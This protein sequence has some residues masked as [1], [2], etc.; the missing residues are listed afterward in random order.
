M[1]ILPGRVVLALTAALLP[2]VA[3]VGLSA[4]STPVCQYALANWPA[5]TYDIQVSANAADLAALRASCG[6]TFGVAGGADVNAALRFREDATLPALTAQVALRFPDHPADRPPI[7][8][9]VLSAERLQGI[10]DSP[11][12]TRLAAELLGGAAAV[13]LFLPAGDPAVDTPAHARLQ[14]TLDEM[15]RTLAPPAA[16]AEPP[17]AEAP[18]AAPF[19]FVALEVPRQDAAE[20]FLRAMLLASEPD[21][22]GL[23]EPLVFPVFGRGRV[24]YA[25]AGAGI[26]RDVLA[27]ACI[28]LT[29]ACSCEVKAQNPGVD[30]LL[31]A[32][33]SRVAGQ[34]DSSF[35]E[36]PPLTGLSA[37]AVAN[38]PPVAVAVAAPVAVAPPALRA[39]SLVPR[40]LAV[41][42][43]AVLA[44]LAGTFVV[45][46]VRRS[47]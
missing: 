41:A 17:A 19:R 44:V 12:R 38:S 23:R 45:L 11:V 47:P 28:F 30:L 34:A 29:G 27:D 8:A 7:W 16:V 35:T 13:F 37:A 9:G 25:I 21:L 26:N 31:R 10:L 5:D 32:D 40:P 20:E 22:A 14:A 2:L 33:W 42:A 18:A 24:L 39:S 36:L 15:A 1:K 46:A 43:V 6:A 3:G 4:C